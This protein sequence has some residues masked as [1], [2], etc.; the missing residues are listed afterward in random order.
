M[1]EELT[2]SLVREGGLSNKEAKE[3]N[4]L[5]DALLAIKALGALGKGDPAGWWRH[6]RP[7][8]Q[9]PKPLRRDGP[10]EGKSCLSVLMNEERGPVQRVASRVS[11]AIQRGRLV[12]GR[13][14][15]KD[16]LDMDVYLSEEGRGD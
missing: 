4:K 11:V 13:W 14:A 10:R 12:F 9:R 15:V 16:L 8:M 6:E 7:A 3:V 2:K 1:I 5:V